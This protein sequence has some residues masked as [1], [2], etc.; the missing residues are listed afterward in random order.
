[1]QQYKVYS[2][3]SSSNPSIILRVD[4]NSSKIFIDGT[5]NSVL[6]NVISN[7]IYTKDQKGYSKKLVELIN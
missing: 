5:T 7:Y 6:G 2:D 3:S 1:M 4:E